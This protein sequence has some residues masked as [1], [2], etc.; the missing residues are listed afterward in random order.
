MNEHGNNDPSDDPGN[1]RTA[2][3]GGP[4]DNLQDDAD[5]EAEDSLLSA[6]GERLR[7]GATPVSAAAIQTVVLRRRT[8]R[9]GVLAGAALVAVTVLAGVLVAGPN[10]ENDPPSADDS[11]AQGDAD[12]PPV[13]GQVEQF[14][15]ALPDEPVDPTKVQLKGSV[16]N[17]AGCPE[18]IGDLR[19]VGAQ[20]V[21]SRGFGASNFGVIPEGVPYDEASSRQAPAATDTAGAGGVAPAETLGTNVQV[22]GVDELDFVKASGS[23]IYDLDGKGNL[24]I[25]DTSTLEVLSTFDVTPDPEGEGEDDS[26]EGPFGPGS[27]A[28]VN[29]LLELDGQVAVFGSETE[30]SDPI[31]GDPS[32]TRA[33]TSYLTVALV[34]ATDPKKPKLADRVRIEGSLVSARLVDGQIRLVTT[35]N[36]ADLG[37]VMPTT[38]TSVPKALEQNRRSV[39]TSAIDDWIPNWQRDGGDAQPLVPC[40]RVYVPD[41]FAG[42]AMTS[43]VSVPIGAAQ[44]EPTATSILAPGSTLYA[45]LDTVAI[46]SEVWVDPIDQ[47]PD[48]FDDWQT[49]I[50]RFSFADDAAPA[51]DGSGIVDGSTVGQFAF[52]EVGESL[53]VVTTNGTPWGQDPDAAIDLTLLRPDGAGELTVESKLDDLA[54]DQGAVDAVRFVDGRVLVSTGFFGRVMLVVDVDDPAKPRRA[55]EVTL[56]GDVG[57][58]HPLPDGQALAIGRR[59]DS[60]GSGDDKFTRSWVQAHL[61]DVGDPDAP[62]I[63][64]TWERPWSED[65]VGDDHH[66]FTFWAKRNLAMWGIRNTQP[67]GNEPQL[68]NHAAVVNVEDAVAEVAVPA[69]NKPDEVPP[70]CPAI[71]VSGEAQDFVGPNDVVLRCDDAATATAEWPRYQC[72]S[73]PGDFVAQF[74]PGEEKNAAFFTCSLA[75]QPTVSRVLVVEDTPIL[76]TDWTL[77]TLD[78][79]SFESVDVTYHPNAQGGAYFR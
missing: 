25:T 37:F 45:G 5:Q 48:K 46:S 58:F 63:V 53:A 11:V 70:P 44:F 68:P 27:A 52:G 41:T 8:R 19:E 77:E 21:G 9:L 12:Q 60:V 34:D 2:D 36:M 35:S 76:Y 20:H 62:E 31:D 55:G 47:D 33:T 3:S 40:E 13:S 4:G 65:S 29:E 71:E 72:S 28:A 79:E 24:R 64:S 51:Y 54:D 1:D 57:Y 7:A 69:A 50:H 61:V 23:L 49:A 10:A 30:V 15:A 74:A 42:V 32:A 75:P 16:S 22:S 59:T 38:P 39:A 56:P 14:L 66:A 6:A 26:E 67:N 73:V 78:P 17:F 18:L 43:M